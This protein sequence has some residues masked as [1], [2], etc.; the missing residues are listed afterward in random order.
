MAYIGA[1]KRGCSAWIPVVD[2]GERDSTTVVCLHYGERKKGKHGKTFAESYPHE[3]TLLQGTYACRFPPFTADKTS[4]FLRNPEPAVSVPVGEQGVPQ[5][6]V[7]KMRCDG[8]KN[9]ESVSLSLLFTG[10][11][12]QPT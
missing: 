2:N 11:L 1:W 4:V 9:R 7:E 3:Q 10:N 8:M 12:L 6:E 5:V